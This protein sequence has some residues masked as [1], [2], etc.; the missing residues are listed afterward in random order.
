MELRGKRSRRK[1]CKSA[2]RNP[3]PMLAQP[4]LPAVITRSCVEPAVRA[5]V[6]CLVDRAEQV[7]RSRAQLGFACLLRRL[8]VASKIPVAE[9]RKEFVPDD[10]HH[11]RCTDE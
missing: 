11:R 4:H 3:T 7:V 5:E 8:T 2:G 6:A 1:Q 10:G 9:P